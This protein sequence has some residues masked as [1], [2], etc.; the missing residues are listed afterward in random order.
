MQKKSI[1][2]GM[3]KVLLNRT[4]YVPIVHKKIDPDAPRFK[5]RLM[6]ILLASQPLSSKGYVMKLITIPYN[7]QYN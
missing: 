6:C 3:N 4:E 7:T 5:R 2:H 1:L